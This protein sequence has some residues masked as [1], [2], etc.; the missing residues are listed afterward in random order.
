ME[1]A[2]GEEGS[3]RQHTKEPGK[4]RKPNRALLARFSDIH[5]VIY[6]HCYRSDSDYS[7]DCV[8]T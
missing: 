7:V 2:K 6:L 4:A 8:V 5:D 1:R 3:T